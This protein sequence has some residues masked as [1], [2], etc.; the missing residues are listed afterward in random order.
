MVMQA[1]G[2]FYIARAKMRFAD[3][4]HTVAWR[5]RPGDILISDIFWF[6]E[7][8][9]TLAPSRRFLFSWS[10]ADVPD[11]VMMA[12][13]AGHLRFALVTS[14]PATGYEPP[15]ALDIP[16]APCRFVRGQQFG[17]D[18]LGLTLSRYSCEGS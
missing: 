12:V 17:L 5:T 2:V 11:M 7:V 15:P 13:R 1:S 4:T 14:V 18:T 9:S 16:G 6:P 3:M 10:A 8:T